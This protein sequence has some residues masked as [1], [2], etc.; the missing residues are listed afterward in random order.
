MRVIQVTKDGAI[1]LNWMWL[2]TF[3][4]QNF[5]V[6][7]ELEK[8]WKARFE[9]GVLFTEE[10]LDEVHQITVDWLCEKFKIEGL[11]QYIEGLKHI[12]QE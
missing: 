9:K 4:G 12:T 7:K 6:L 3:I 11:K 8:F 5:M 10:N 2:P 1:E